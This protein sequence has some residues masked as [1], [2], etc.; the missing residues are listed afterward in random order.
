MRLRHEVVWIPEARVCSV[1]V[2]LSSALAVV[3]PRL[4]VLVVLG[5]TSVL[6]MTLALLLHFGRQRKP[7]CNPDCKGLP[8]VITSV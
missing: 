2:E 6:F 7:D 1:S 8:A 4:A 5:H 3:A